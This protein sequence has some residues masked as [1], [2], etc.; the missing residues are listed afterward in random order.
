MLSN[1]A[2]AYQQEL[3]RSSRRDPAMENH[4]AKIET[5]GISFS[6]RED[7]LSPLGDV[8]ITLGERLK[9]QNSCP[10]LSQGQA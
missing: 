9:G 2:R 7:V 8:L 1:F 6:L 4:L 5:I 3:L 10:E